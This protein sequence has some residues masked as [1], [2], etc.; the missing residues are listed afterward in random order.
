MPHIRMWRRSIL[1]I[2]AMEEDLKKAVDT[3]RKGGVILYP[4]DTIWGIGCDATNS[5]A[6]K[7]VYEIKRRAES[8]AMLVLAD[9]MATVKRYVDAVPDMAYTLDEISDK[10]VTIIYDNAKS[11]A[12]ELLGE[13]RS[14]GIRVTREEFSRQLC[15][16]FRKP[17]VSTS[18]NI[19]GEPSPAFFDKI[20]PAIKEAADYVVGYRQ[21]D[22]T[23]HSPSS[24]IRLSA[25]NVIKILRH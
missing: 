22:R 8:K 21:T 24:V 1:T 7:R 18:A 20:S 15:A 9:S 11:L 25:G 4:T 2:I 5:A 12:P 23:P 14:V 17:I 13:N 3:L 16:R 19:A 10:P 6:V